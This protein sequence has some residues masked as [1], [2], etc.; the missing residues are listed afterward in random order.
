MTLQGFE[1]EAQDGISYTVA[2]EVTLSLNPI[3]VY[4]HIYELV[5]DATQKTW[6]R[7]QT[8]NDRSSHMER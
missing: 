1:G 7:K 8:W 3:A 6:N 5:Y 4:E 2:S